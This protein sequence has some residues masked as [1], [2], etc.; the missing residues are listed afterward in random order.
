MIKSVHLKNFK[1]F[2]EA[3]IPLEPLT[4]FVGPNSSGKTTV[5]EVISQVSRLDDN[6]SLGQ[7]FTG[8][9]S[10]GQIKGRLAARD[11][12][13]GCVVESNGKSFKID[14]SLSGNKASPNTTQW[15]LRTTLDGKVILGA[16]FEEENNGPNEGPLKVEIRVPGRSVPTGQRPKIFD[17]GLLLRLN[18]VQI[19]APSK[20]GKLQISDAGFGVPSVLT[21]MAL[22][23]PEEFQEFQAA[24]RAVVPAF[25]RLRMSR[26]TVLDTETQVFREGDK[27]IT[28]PIGREFEGYKL[29][30]DMKNATD[31]PGECASEGTL[32]VIAILAVLMGPTQPKLVLLDDI[33]R[34]LH[35]RAMGDLIKVIRQLLEKDPELQIV[36]TSH[37][38]YLL[39]H[40]KYKEVR[41]TSLDAE[42]NARVGS[43]D[44]HPDFDRW[45][46]VMTPGEFWSMVGESWITK[47]NGKP[48]HA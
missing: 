38:P 36:A 32:L 16:S 48:A 35:P 30:L 24:V 26:I 37:S 19:A 21:E 7:S 9:M 22:N 23:Q 40:L 41:L 25:E 11:S 15:K 42:G 1:L 12:Q 2:K 6:Q 33:D 3:N 46:D 44:Q 4:V 27:I 29:V 47:K 45:K 14:A 18:S 31:V 17:V 34:G 20:I 8:R 39:E 13:F 43:L 28:Q 5:L 10:P